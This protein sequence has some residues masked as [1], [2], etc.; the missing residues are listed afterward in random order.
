MADTTPLR[1][2]TERLVLRRP[3]PADATRLAEVANDRRIA[4][5]MTSTFPNP[6]GPSDAHEF[7]ASCGTDFAIITRERVG[8]LSA[9]L[10][11]MAGYSPASEDHDD[12]HMFGY[13]LTPDAWGQ[14]IATE[15]AGAVLDH[16]LAAEPVRRI[17]ARVYAWNPPS[18][19]VL[20]K[21]G[22]RS[23]GAPATAFGASTR[24]PTSSSTDFCPANAELP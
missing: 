23:R 6:Y 1:L 12:S 3:E 13:W 24:S 17:E 19:S 16:L 20:E 5:N 18:A 4:R 8:S 14:G 21:L 9:G 11:G 22:S 10:V 2:E 15:A 7:I